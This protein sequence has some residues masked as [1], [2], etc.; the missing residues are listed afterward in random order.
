MTTFHHGALIFARM[1]VCKTYGARLRAPRRPIAVNPLQR[2]VPRSK[3]RRTSCPLFDAARR[4]SRTSPREARGDAPRPDTSKRSPR[5]AGVKRAPEQPGATRS[6]A[7]RSEHGEDCEERSL[8]PAPRGDIGASGRGAVF[9]LNRYDIVAPQCHSRASGNPGAPRLKVW[10]SLDS[11]LRGNDTGSAACR[12][13][14]RRQGPVLAILAML[15]SLRQAAR[16]SGLLR[17]SLD[18]GCARRPSGRV[19][20]RGVRPSLRSGVRLALRAASNKGRDEEEAAAP[21]RTALSPLRAS[22]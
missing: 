22:H 10:L 6:F 16:G 15:A 2:L 4:A 21:T 18:P 17:A 13:A 5:G 12:R 8:T 7:K 1:T 19:G 20:T 3:I 14:R 9:R 11:R